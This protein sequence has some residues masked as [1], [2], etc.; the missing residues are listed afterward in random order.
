[1]ADESEFSIDNMMDSGNLSTSSSSSVASN[2]SNKQDDVMPSQELPI[3]GASSSNNNKQATNSGAATSYEIG[4]REAASTVDIVD[5]LS[6]RF[7]D[8]QGENG[9]RYLLGMLIQKISRGIEA[10][11]EAIANGALPVVLQSLEYHKDD[12]AILKLGLIC[13]EK[14]TTLNEGAALLGNSEHLVVLSEI[15]LPYL[16]TRN[17]ANLVVNILQNILENNEKGRTML[18]AAET[19]TVNDLYYATIFDILISV[20]EKSKGAASIASTCLRNLEYSLE[21]HQNHHVFADHRQCLRRFCLFIH[22]IDA[23][24]DLFHDSLKILEKLLEAN[25]GY[26][27]RAL[28]ILQNAQAHFSLADETAS[29]ASIRLLISITHIDKVRDCIIIADGII[30]AVSLLPKYPIATKLIENLSKNNNGVK[31]LANSVFA[32]RRLRN[33]INDEIAIIVL[34]HLSQLNPKEIQKF[35][36]VTVDSAIKAVQSL[37]DR[38]QAENNDALQSAGLN[39][40]AQ[41]SK[42]L[43]FPRESLSDLQVTKS[44]IVSLATS[45]RRGEKNAACDAIRLLNSMSHSPEMIFDLEKELLCTTLLQTLNKFGSPIENGISVDRIVLSVLTGSTEILDMP[46]VDYQNSLLKTRQILQ[47][48][49]NHQEWVSKLEENLRIFVQCSTLTKDGS[50]L[51]SLIQSSALPMIEYMISHYVN[52]GEARATGGVEIKLVY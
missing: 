36:P 5:Q 14:Q 30:L 26:Q 37:L 2:N 8:K 18:A 44:A 33:A 20:L 28:N 16:S 34:N 13:L 29:F 11:R 51:C 49:I 6:R 17:I 15:V 7:Q 27:T 25:P 38:A 43:H 31:A 32:P 46:E 45:T 42:D 48:L 3:G 39:A 19:P 50:V 52:V 24:A 35:L 41:L 9:C 22:E 12:A 23:D 10:L 21:K 4:S 47:T 40:L 1:M